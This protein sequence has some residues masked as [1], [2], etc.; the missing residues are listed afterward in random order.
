[1]SYAIYI[2]NA[3]LESEWP[4]EDGPRAEWTVNGMEHPE[5]PFKPDVTG[6]SNGCHPGY[7]QWDIA[8]EQ[9][10]LH[11]AFF[12]AKRG[13]LREHP[14]I[15]LLT[16]EHVAEFEAARTAFLL[17]HPIERPGICRCRGCNRIDGDDEAVHDPALNFN[18]H[19]L[20]W[21][22]WWTR[23]ALANCE[24]PAVYNR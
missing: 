21:L 1:M 14:G 7:S 4:G 3:E 24:R 18:M 12:D 22:C 13:L 6:R 5:A 8:M 19:R 16:Q 10:G 11:D 15:Q 9:V 23:Y 20:N 2:G 17:A